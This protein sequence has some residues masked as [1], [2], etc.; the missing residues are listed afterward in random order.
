VDTPT[1]SYVVGRAPRFD[2]AAAGYPDGPSLDDEAADAVEYVE[3]ITW[4]KLDESMPA[5]WARSAAR[6]V[7]M[8]TQQQVTQADPDMVESAAD[9]LT[10]SQGAGGASESRRAFSDFKSANEALLVN[11]WPALND[12][13]WAVMTPEARAWWLAFLKGEM[14]ALPAAFLEG[15]FNVVQVA[16]DAAHYAPYENV[17]PG[18]L[19]P[20]DPNDLPYVPEPYGGDDPLPGW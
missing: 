8:R 14:P 3:N 18:Y 10:N 6:A 20:P 16:W 7:V 11:R 2:W 15:G 13:L 4:R 12:L 5:A 17:T 9:E 1:G 19:N